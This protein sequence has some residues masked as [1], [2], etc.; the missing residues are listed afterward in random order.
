MPKPWLSVE[1]KCF[2]RGTQTHWIETHSLHLV[3]TCQRQNLS[4]GDSSMKTKSAIFQMYAPTDSEVP[5]HESGPG[6][7]VVLF[8]AFV[9][10]VVGVIYS[11]H[12][13]K[14][15]YS[16][17]ALVML[18]ALEA[19]CLCTII[20]L[21][22]DKKRGGWER[23]TTDYKLRIVQAKADELQYLLG[24]HFAKD[25]LFRMTEEEIRERA[26]SVLLWAVKDILEAQSN[27][28]GIPRIDSPTVRQ[29]IDE[30]TN[31]HRSGLEADLGK[32]YDGLLRFGVV[33]SGGY[34]KYFDEVR[35]KYPHLSEM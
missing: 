32:L 22:L 31:S 13:N 8:L 25:L 12:T 27:R 19:M 10:V 4:K 3:V 24:W 6:L 30:A 7:P 21:L 33:E 17:A 5:S 15:G 26:H 29:Y 9:A 14:E 18:V 23:L 2:S 16:L 28:S 1:V 34:G 11:L 20:I 35:E